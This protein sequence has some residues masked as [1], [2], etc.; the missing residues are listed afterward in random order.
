MKKQIIN[1]GLVFIL[2][3]PLIVFASGFKIQNENYRANHTDT[4]E[5]IKKRGTLLIGVDDTFVPMDF[6]KKNGQLVGYD[7][8]LSRAVAKVLGLKADFQSI[9]W[10][11]KETEL[12]NGTIDCIWNGYTATPSRQKR[13]AFSRVYELS[14][15]SLVVRKDSKI[16]NFADMKGKTL[17]IQ[18]SSTAQTDFDKYPQVLKKLVKGQKPI[19]YQD[20]SSAFMDLQAGRTQGVL[21]GTVYAGYYATHIA[22]N[23]NYKLISASAYPADRVAIGMR[24][25][26]RTLINKINYALG[27]L[28]KNGTLR[29][30]NKKWL[31]I[32]SNYLGPVAEF[33]KSNNNR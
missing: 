32:N 24:K 28:Q 6:R 8:D 18:E 23:N 16:K 5:R 29:R 14:G 20:N 25:G 27:V 11:M 2:L 13:I 1:F 17:G 10:S 12:K 30:I 19:L 33:Q 3:L 4:W 31:G 7:V 26:D 15:Q 21:A 9:D 22:N